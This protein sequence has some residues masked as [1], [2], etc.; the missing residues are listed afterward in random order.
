MF[1]GSKREDTGRMR[2]KREANE[3]EGP[4]AAGGEKTSEKTYNNG[5]L[6]E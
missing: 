6:V 2:T 3:Q 4:S 1:K 5:T